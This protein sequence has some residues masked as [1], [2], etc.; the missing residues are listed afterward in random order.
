MTDSLHPRLSERVA[1]E[2][3]IPFVDA[4]REWPEWLVRMEMFARGT[5]QLYRMSILHKMMLG[6]EELQAYEDNQQKIEEHIGFFFSEPL[7]DGIEWF[8]VPDA[9]GEEDE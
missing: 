8:T 7:D 2:C 9:K 1:T 6:K 5:F 3:E 4:W